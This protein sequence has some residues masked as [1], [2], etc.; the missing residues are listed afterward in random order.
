[1]PLDELQ[2]VEIVIELDKGVCPEE[3]QHKFSISASDLKD[4]E[5]LLHHKNIPKKRKV[6]RK[7]RPETNRMLIVQKLLQGEL[8]ELLAEQNEI[9]LKTLRSWAKKDGI[10]W[11]RGWS[12]LTAAERREIQALR[13]EGEAWE[14]IA[15]AYGLHLKVEELMPLLPYQ[16][17]STAEIGLLMEIFTSEPS[18][19][20][21]VACQLAS[22]AGMEIASKA[23]A[24][25]KRRWS[26]FRRPN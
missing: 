9:S 16:T 14:E 25:Y 1:M 2:R 3:L 7:K 10:P 13:E 8:P 4:I 20:I 11:S 26:H 17:L 12:E 21:G 19:S 15:G 23:V 24:S 18:I 5:K 22:Q 6:Q